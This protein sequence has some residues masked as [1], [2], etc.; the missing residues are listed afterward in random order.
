MEKF[1]ESKNIIFFLILSLAFKQIQADGNYLN[2]LGFFLKGS[3]LHL[4]RSVYRFFLSQLVA[5]NNYA[6][7]QFP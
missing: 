7:V 2:Q 3:L 5:V 4:R 1:S 6:K